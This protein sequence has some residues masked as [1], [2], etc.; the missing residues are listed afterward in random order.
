MMAH[1]AFD[2][3]EYIFFVF[4]NDAMLANS[5]LDRESSEYSLAKEARLSLATM[6]GTSKS[7]LLG[8][9]RWSTEAG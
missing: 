2:R 9:V 8:D 4:M 5:E 3:G 7:G 1:S 6:A